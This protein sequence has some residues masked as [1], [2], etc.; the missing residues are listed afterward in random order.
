MTDTLILVLSLI[1]GGFVLFCLVFKVDSSRTKQAPWLKGH[2]THRG[3]YTS[4]QHRSEN[5]LGAFKQSIEAGYGIELDVQ[6]SQDGKVYVFHDDDLFR[7]T[8]T[9]GLL[10]EKKSEEL[11]ALRLMNSGE[12]IPL[13]SDVLTLVRGQVPLLVELKSTI[14]KE[15]SVKAVVQVMKDYEGHFAYCSFDPL[16]L[17]LLKKY[18]Q[19]RLRGLN[20]EYSLNKKQFGWTTRMILQWALLALPSQASEDKISSL[21]ETVIFEHYHPS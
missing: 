4:D 18:D 14:R 21:C 16:M 12:K 8:G 3:F 10:E 2:Y 20:M 11:D 1:L 7:M 19:D 9:K 15:E 6:L 17:G 5:S 13:L